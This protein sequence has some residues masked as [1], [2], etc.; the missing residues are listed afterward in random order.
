MSPFNN[1]PLDPYSGQKGV[2]LTELMVVLGLMGILLAI[3]IPRMNMIQTS[4]LNGAARVVWSDMHLAKMTA[5][6]END[7]I[8]VIFS[9]SGYHFERDSDNTTIYTRNISQ[10]YIGA[11]LTKSSIS[12]IRF[13]AK[14]TAIPPSQT[15]S[16][17]LDGQTK[18]FTVLSS[19]RIGG[20]S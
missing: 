13:S 20:I 1:I 9:S 11:S 14:G 16:I 15:I 5:I 17:N 4:R 12:N 3:A 8:N 6:K 10:E 7:Q 2:T 18:S 19:G